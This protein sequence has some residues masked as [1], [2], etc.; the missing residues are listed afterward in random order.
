MAKN[1]PNSNK[2]RGKAKLAD[3]ADR[4]ELYEAAVQGVESEIDFVE[5]EFL[6]LR[7]RRAHSLREDFCGTG[8]SSCEWVR[9]RV[10][11]HAI[12][13][14]LDD[15]VLAWGQQPVREEPRPGLQD[16]QTDSTE[17]TACQ[18]ERRPGGLVLQCRRGLSK[19]RAQVS[20]TLATLCSTDVAKT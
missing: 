6:A 1:K 18:E 9:R 7:G 15:S 12:G 8:N 10:G 14:D 20:V 11:N 5:K 13:V 16:V 2:S 4:H 19:G 3:Q 17:R